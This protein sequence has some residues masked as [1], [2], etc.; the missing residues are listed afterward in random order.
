MASC[1]SCGTTIL[2]GGK[3]LG[4]YRFCSDRCASRAALL[5]RAAQIPAELVRERASAIRAG[6][7][8]VC[9]GPGPVDVHTSHQV[10]SVLI[11]TSWRSDPRLSCRSCGVKAQ[12]QGALLSLVAGWWGFPWGIIMTPVQIARNLAGMA[13][14]S[15]GLAPSPELEKI[16]RTLLAQSPGPADSARS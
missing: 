10:Y 6:T 5:N 12:A 14:S 11:V 13:S 1:D 3:T 9:E 16:T 7:C 2:F 15:E 4:S 8:P